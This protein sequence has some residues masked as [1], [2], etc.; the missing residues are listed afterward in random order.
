[1]ETAASGSHLAQV[2]WDHEA[3]GFC[4]NKLVEETVAHYPHECDSP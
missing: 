4:G 3:G 1:M 2:S